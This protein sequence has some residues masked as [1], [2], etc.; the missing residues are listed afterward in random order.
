MVSR[1]ALHDGEA[2]N[3]ELLT[4]GARLLGFE[5]TPHQIGAFGQYRSL[6]SFWNSR[7]NLTAV[8]DPALIVRLHFLDC[9]SVVSVL[10]RDGSILD[11]G[12]GA[13]FPGIPVKLMLPDKR[14]Y[15]VEPRRKRA[16][17]L[18]QVTRVLKLTDV[19]VVESRLED[20]SLQPIIPPVNETITRGLSDIRGFLKVSGELLAPSGLAVLMQGPRGA[21]VLD[22]L[23]SGLSGCGLIEGRSI[24][25]E[26]P[27]GGERR[28]ILTFPK[29]R[30]ASPGS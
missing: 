28:T 9:L 12:S 13:G 1:T 11:I 5:L 30:K 6:L 15:L 22:D 26:L 20:L 16:N 21:A 19:H 2:E 10:R 17:F 4:A 18:R 3:E 29:V 7:L 23:R 14:V 24:R 8:R 25:F 27:F